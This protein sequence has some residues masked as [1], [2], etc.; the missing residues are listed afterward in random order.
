MSCG[1]VRIIIV[2]FKLCCAVCTIHSSRI[3]FHS[4]KLNGGHFGV[5]VKRNG[6]HFGVDLGII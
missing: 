6:D 1:Q 5:D 3:S 4:E 2:K